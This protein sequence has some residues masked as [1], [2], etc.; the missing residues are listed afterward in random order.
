MDHVVE[1]QLEVWVLERHRHEAELLVQLF[2]ALR[3]DDVCG[4]NAREA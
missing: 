3:G 2:A 4:T 1:G